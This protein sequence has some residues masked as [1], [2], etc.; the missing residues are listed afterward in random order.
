ML[1]GGLSRGTNT[2]LIGPSGAGKTS[3]A[4]RCMRTALERGEKGAKKKSSEPKAKK[5]KKSK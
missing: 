5:E 1:G 4:M 3:T 2:L